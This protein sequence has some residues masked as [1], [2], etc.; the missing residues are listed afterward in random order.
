MSGD[1]KWKGVSWCRDQQKWKATIV[2]PNRCRM[3][4]GYYDYERDAAIAY[5]KM[6]ASLGKPTN[7]LRK[8]N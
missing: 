2:M 5:D 8:R 3:T 1:S 4:L 6:A 7:I